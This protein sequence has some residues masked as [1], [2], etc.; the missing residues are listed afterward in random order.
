MLGFWIIITH[1]IGAYVTSS[2]YV[3]SKSAGNVMYSLASAALYM[4]PF[5]VFLPLSPLSLL[6]VFL[7]RFLSV[8]F[9]LPDYVV[10]AKN[11]IAP[12]SG[13]MARVVREEDIVDSA[14]SVNHKISLHMVSFVIHCFVIALA[15]IVL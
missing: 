3:Q 2:E 6:V 12:R 7:F 13:R 14:S 10:W 11:Q 15:V 5:I 8:L 4:I 1:A 9:R